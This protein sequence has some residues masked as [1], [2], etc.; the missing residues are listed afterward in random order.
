MTKLVKGILIGVGTVVLVCVVAVGLVIGLA[1]YG[2]RG[3][4]RSGN[5]A[6]ATQN[7]QTILTSQFRYHTEY[8]SYGTFE[9]L[10]DKD[11]L[12]KRFAASAPTI[13]GYKYVLTVRPAEPDQKA[14][15]TVNADPV[16][17]SAGTKHFFV[18][19]SSETV[20]VS[21]NKPA[22]G[23]DPAIRR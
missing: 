21:S 17:S 7:I 15:F 20:H 10:V 18:D 5:E 1:F 6:A 12:S 22:S 11:F 2:Y 8:G 16:N 13:D 23:N 14:S 9:Q 4:V 3:A 19:S